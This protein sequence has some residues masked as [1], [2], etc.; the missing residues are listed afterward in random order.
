MSISVSGSPPEGIRC[1]GLES[2]IRSSSRLSATFSTLIEAPES[3]P[4]RIAN[5]EVTLRWTNAVSF[6]LADS[7]GSVMLHDSR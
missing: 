7:N 4:A 2:V 3:P 5:S 6:H 1:F